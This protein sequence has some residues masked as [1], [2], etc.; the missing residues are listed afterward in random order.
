M[1]RIVFWDIDHTLIDTRGVGRELSA[2]AFERVTGCRM[3]R[4]PRID[5]MTE[6]VIFRETARLHGLNTGR[7]DFE[8]FAEALAQVHHQR[9]AELRE[10]G[11]ALPGAA[12]VL[13]ALAAVRDI[14]QTV[15]SG[16]IRP[17]AE[18]KLATFGLDRHIQW[19][20]GAYG[21]DADERAELVRIALKRAGRPPSD[22][23]L[24]D[25]TPAGVEAG[26]THGVR[27]V[28]VATGRSTPAELTAAGAD[29][30]LLNLT[31]TEAVLGA[32]G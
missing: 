10:R 25:D 2:V 30:V 17:V 1:R 31:D 24:V 6:S 27:V 5:G 26:L 23:V 13:E 28:A 9:V 32:L 8:R 22:A 21:E 14:E 3:K 16:N 15:V 19:E 4:Q 11:H 12:A 29:V 20:L 7:G 18:I